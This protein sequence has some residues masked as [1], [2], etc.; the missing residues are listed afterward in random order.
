[1]KMGS[2]LVSTNNRAVDTYID[3]KLVKQPFFRPLHNWTKVAPIKVSPKSGEKGGFEGEIS[4]FRYIS[5]T[6]NPREAYEF[7]EKVRR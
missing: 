1:M 7:T 5:R 3:G 4:K 6:V 2:I